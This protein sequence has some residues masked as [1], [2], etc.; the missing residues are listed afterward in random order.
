M[1]LQVRNFNDT[2]LESISVADTAFAVDFNEGLVHQVITSYRTIGR[3]GTKAQKSRSDVSGGGAKPWKQKG[4]GRARA[5]TRSSPIWRSGGVTFAAKPHT[6][7]VK[8]N[9]RMYRTALKSML[10]ELARQD[11]L[12]VVNEFSLP[13]IKTKALQEKLEGLNL[14]KT[15]IVLEGY[16]EAIELSARNL[17]YVNVVEVAHLDPL[18]LINSDHVLFTLPALKMIEERLQ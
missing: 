10:S 14:K 6:Y 18:S 4:T 11:R 13:E 8:I 15:L 5:G 12:V 7:K 1:E 3:A 2:K 9:K 16:D 17:H